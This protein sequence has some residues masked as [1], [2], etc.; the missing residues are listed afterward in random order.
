[1]YRSE[2]YRKVDIRLEA[3]AR[4]Q[5]TSRH[6]NNPHPWSDTKIIVAVLEISEEPVCAHWTRE[7]CKSLTNNAIIR[8]K[9]SS[10]EQN[11]LETSKAQIA[12]AKSGGR[13][14]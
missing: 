10:L 12:G 8:I 13:S 6:R 7:L 4:E 14:R 3:H 2:P 1:M 9:V 11:V 5:R